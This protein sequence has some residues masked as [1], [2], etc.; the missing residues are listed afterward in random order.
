MS[1]S[2]PEFKDLLNIIVR[3]LLF[4]C[5]ASFKTLGAIQSGP[6]VLFTLIY[7]VLRYCILN[8]ITLAERNKFI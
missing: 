5:F 8:K 3:G 4:S 7:E 2:P 6:G 1:G